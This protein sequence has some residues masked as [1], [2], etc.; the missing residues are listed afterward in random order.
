VEREERGGKMEWEIEEEGAGG[1]DEQEG[2]RRTVRENSDRAIGGREE[3]NG[4]KRG[5][6][7]RGGRE[8]GE[9]E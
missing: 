4:E 1:R 2:E 5:M 8:E 9:R 6:E 3:R 7:G